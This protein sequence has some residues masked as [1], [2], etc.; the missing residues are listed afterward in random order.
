MSVGVTISNPSPP[1]GIQLVT[2]SNQHG[3]EPG[4]PE[5]AAQAAADGTGPDHHITCHDPTLS[6]S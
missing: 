2:A 4:V 5:A 1:E 3:V 6:G